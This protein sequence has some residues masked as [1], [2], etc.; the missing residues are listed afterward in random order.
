MKRTIVLGA[1]PDPSRY[2]NIACRMLDNAGIE[3]IPI[4]IKK[5]EIL[6]TEILNLGDKPKIDNIHTITIYLSPQNQKEWYSYVLS[7]NPKRL[8]FNPGAENSELKEMAE[9]SGLFV[10]NACNLVLIQLGQF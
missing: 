7:L 1:S 10:E 9:K 8:I 4:G 5:G 6:G 2:S 3:F